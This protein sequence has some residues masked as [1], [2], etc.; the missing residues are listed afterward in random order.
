[1]ERQG[2]ATWRSMGGREDNHPGCGVV[3]YLKTFTLTSTSN[4]ATH[5]KLYLPAGRELHFFLLIII[6]LSFE[7]LY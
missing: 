7:A 1:M 2:D 6:L 3:F 4:P 5:L